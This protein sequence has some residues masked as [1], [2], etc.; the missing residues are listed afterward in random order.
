MQKYGFF[1][2]LSQGGE[3]D[4]KYNANDY[5]DNL[6]VVISNGVLRSSN[7]D[8]KVTASGRVV[9]VAAGKA[10]INGHYYN[11]TSEYQFD[12]VSQ[13]TT[14]NRYDRVMLR[15]NNDIN[16]RNILLTYVKG[17]EAANAVPPEPTREGNI[18]D[19]VL[20]TIYSVASSQNLIITDERGTEGLC[21]WLYSNSKGYLFKRYDWQTTLT[22]AS[23]VVQFNIPQYEQDKT[24]IEVYV[25]GFCKL[26]QQIIL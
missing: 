5:S 6:A 24:F 7:D 13:P 15:F 21:G 14:G 18:Y 10:W 26:K 17:T 8:L 16:S 25:N 11:N 20:A 2:A 22:S 23:S 3:Y 9:K 19:I 1:N 4:R 12:E